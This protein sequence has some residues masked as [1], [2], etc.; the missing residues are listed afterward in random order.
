[1]RNMIDVGEPVKPGGGCYMM[2]KFTRQGRRQWHH[3][4]QFFKLVRPVGRDPLSCN[5]SWRH[6]NRRG[7]RICS[8][9]INRR[10]SGV[11]NMRP[12]MTRE[13][14]ASALSPGGRTSAEK[15]PVT[16]ANSPCRADR[17]KRRRVR[18]PGFS[19]FVV[20]RISTSRSGRS[21][22]IRLHAQGRAGCTW[23]T[24]DRSGSLMFPPTAEPSPWLPTRFQPAPGT[25]FRSCAAR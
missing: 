7:A 4:F 9:C 21:S 14:S 10:N 23:D 11:L 17:L 15:C 20:S 18:C 2:A 13:P 3:A 22:G 25:R 24:A 6:D 19:M 1:M 16:G 8:A 12:A 5:R